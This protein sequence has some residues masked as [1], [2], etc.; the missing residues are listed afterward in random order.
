MRSWISATNSLAG[1]VMIAKVRIHSPEAGSF[2]FSHSLQMRP[3]AAGK[4]AGRER[5]HEEATRHRPRAGRTP[6][7]QEMRRT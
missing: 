2:Q 7:T 6:R 5:C 3:F 4:V 1:V